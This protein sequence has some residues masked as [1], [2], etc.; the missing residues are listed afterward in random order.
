MTTKI[1]FVPVDL[2]DPH[3]HNPRRD[4]GDLPWWFKQCYWCGETCS[5]WADRC[6]HCWRWF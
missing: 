2:I 5:R 6:H 1:E 3:P 4:L